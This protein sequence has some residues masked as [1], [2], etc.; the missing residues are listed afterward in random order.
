MNSYLFLRYLHIISAIVFIGGIFARQLVRALA[1]QTDDVHVL[2]SLSRASGRIE[3]GMIIPGHSAVILFGILLALQMRAPILGFLQ[4]AAQNWLLVSN[5]LLLVGFLPV[6]LVFLPRGKK[7]DA[8]L[9]EAL[10]VGRVTPALRAALDDSL[11]RALHI[12]EVVG[13]ALILWLMV[14]KPF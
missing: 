8:A 12:G 6:P 5:L 11:I 10:A 1:K 9:S 3:N 14:F 13:V 2:A 4:G 7:Y